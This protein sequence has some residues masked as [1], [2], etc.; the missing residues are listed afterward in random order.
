MRRVLAPVLAVLA[1]WALTPAA[2]SAAGA[3]NRVIGGTDA[4]PSSVP[5]QALVLPDGYLCGGVILDAT[6]VATAA[7]CARDEDTGAITPPSAIAVH[8]GITNRFATGQA[9]AVAGVTIDPDY[10][11]E[12][13]TGDLAILRLAAPGLAL[14]ATTVKAIGLTDAGYA[15]SGSDPLTLSGWGSTVARSPYDETTPQSPSDDLQVAN[16]LHVS[17]GCASV[18]SPFDDDKLL[19]AG[20]TGLDACQGDSGGP[21]VAQVGGV[22]KLAGVVTGGAGCAWSGYPGYYARVAEPGNHDFLLQRGGGAQIPDPA[23]P[24]ALTGV[25]KVGNLLTCG[26]GTWQGSYAY[27]ITFVADGRV[28]ARGVTQLPLTAALAGAHV[29]CL[30]DAASTTGTAEAAS[31]GVLV[32]AAD[33]VVVPAPP[34]APAPAPA[35][36][37]TPA[38]AADATPPTARIVKVRCARTVCVLDVRVEDAAPSSGVRSVAG[39]VTTTYRSTCVRKHKRHACAK[40]VVQTLKSTVVGP[41][42]YRLTTPRLRKGKHTFSLVAT[43]GHGNRQAKAATASRSTR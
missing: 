1:A 39:K 18:Y 13:A 27:N 15:P 38:P 32:A 36:A 21:L 42:T 3:T 4:A 40:T 35:P 9:P 8:A 34:A 17:N 16:G 33:P 22:P 29:S 41:G 26:V 43:D 11:P 19:C 30:V 24:P 2:A 5:W 20:Q 14:N 31:P 25:A 23:A 12:A 10:D 37:P 28:V 7:H 6:H